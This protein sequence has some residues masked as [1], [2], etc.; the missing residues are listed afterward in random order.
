MAADNVGFVGLGRMG[1]RMALRLVDS[2]LVFGTDKALS[3]KD[4]AEANGIT[5]VDNSKSL[6]S[7]CRHIFIVA[8]SENDVTEIIFRRNRPHSWDRF[9]Y[10]DYRLCDCSTQLHASLSG[11]AFPRLACKAPRL[12]YR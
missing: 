6:A 3:Q 1:S 11:E 9:R 12:P 10:N 7:I 4:S 8:G 2:Y 5:W